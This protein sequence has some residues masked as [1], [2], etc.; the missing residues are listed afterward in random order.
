MSKCENCD[1]LA[2]ELAAAVGLMRKHVPHPQCTVY[3]NEPHEGCGC[4]NCDFG[5]FL[6]NP[7][8]R[9]E[10]MLRVVEAAKGLQGVMNETDELAPQVYKKELHEQFLECRWNLRKALK[11]LDGEPEKK[12][13]TE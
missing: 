9:A 10:A 13:G 11:A 1:R 2:A 12:G 5:L 7:H 3:G 6:K 8:P 4:L